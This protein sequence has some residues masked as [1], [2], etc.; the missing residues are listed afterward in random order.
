[1]ARD[2]D[3]RGRYGRGGS[4]YGRGDTGRSSYRGGDRDRDWSDRAGDEVRS[5]FGD[6]DAERRRM[7][8]DR[9][10]GRDYS[11]S[12]GNRGSYRDDDYAR[13]GS[14]GNYG[15]E[16][17]RNFGGG[18]GD[19][20]SSGSAFGRNEG[21]NYGY[22]NRGS[23]RAD[24][25]NQSGTGERYGSGRGYENNRYGRNEERGFFERAGD[26][27]SSW[28]GDEDAE[29][30]REM[31]ARHRGRGPKNYTRSDDRIRED[32][33][34]RLS[35]D[36]HLDASDIDVTVKDGEVTLGGTVQERFAKRHAEDLVERVSGV[37]HVQ[38]NL[39]VSSQQQGYGSTDTSGRAGTTGSSTTGSTTSG[40]GT[41]GTTG[42]T[43]T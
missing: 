12:Y 15:S 36:Q 6:D 41:T 10:A 39:R 27:V 29:R 21:S 4:D 2:W 38:N 18:Y 24:Y 25:R 9:A 8:D 7:Q 14:S 16:R 37:K 3:D 11:S 34:D 35:D 19:Y 28:F 13:G 43:R 22:D 20:G 23:N 5:W 40:V 42:S 32:V 1:M 26:E 31:D 30:R 33:N 17:S